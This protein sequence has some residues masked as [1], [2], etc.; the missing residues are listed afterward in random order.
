MPLIEVPGVGQFEAPDDATPEQ[1]EEFARDAY[2]RGQKRAALAE[3]GRQARIAGR[4][5]ELELGA[6]DLAER[7]AYTLSRFRPDLAVR[8]VVRLP[9]EISRALG[10]VP[11][12]APNPEDR[13]LVTPEQVHNA[14]R[15]TQSFSKG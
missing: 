10:L 5:Q 14:I 11:Q 8:D 6:I 2:T 9:F 13:P 7:G 12:D 15:A 1:L 4:Q 3:E